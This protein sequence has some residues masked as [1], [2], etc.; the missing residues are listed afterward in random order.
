[1]AIDHLRC[2]KLFS[3]RKRAWLKVEEIR[4]EGGTTFV[5]CTSSPCL[6]KRVTKPVQLSPLTTPFLPSARYFYPSLV[7]VFVTVKFIKGNERSRR[8][9]TRLSFHFSTFLSFQQ[10]LTMISETSQQFPQ[11]LISRNNFSSS[12]S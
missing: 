3:T 1:M 8:E 5:K 2:D 4:S 10:N 6:R 11:L 12:Q 9:L 7:R